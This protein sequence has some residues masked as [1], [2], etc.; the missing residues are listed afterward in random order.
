MAASAGVRDW[1]AGGGE[2]VAWEL[3]ACTPVSLFGMAEG[4]WPLAVLPVFWSRL[5]FGSLNSARA[6]ATEPGIS[7]LVATFGDRLVNAEGFAAAVLTVAPASLRT[8]QQW[9]LEGCSMR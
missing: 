6:L 7:A 8:Y 4:N 9:R 3:A 1:E 2:V 5:A